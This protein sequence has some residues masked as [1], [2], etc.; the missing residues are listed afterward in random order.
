MFQIHDE[1]GSYDAFCFGFSLGCLES[2]YDL[3]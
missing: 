3:S 1:T 2:L